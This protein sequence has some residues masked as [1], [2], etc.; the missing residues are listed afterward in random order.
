M[1]ITPAARALFR[2][3]AGVSIQSGTNDGNLQPLETMQQSCLFMILLKNNRLECPAARIL[4][5]SA[6]Q[7][8]VIA[9]VSV[10]SGGGWGTGV[11]SGYGDYPA[12]GGFSAGPPGC[13]VHPD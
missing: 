10:S 9:P 6:P 12:V 3:A 11:D 13:K 7:Q 1:V 8:C 5:G 4:S 2:F